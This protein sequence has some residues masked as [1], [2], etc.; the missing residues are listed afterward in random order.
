MKSINIDHQNNTR[1][2]K[3]NNFRELGGYPT[4]D[5]RTLKYR[6]LFRS[7]HLSA[8]SRR[9]LRSMEE[10]KLCSVVDFRS[11]QENEKQPDRLPTGLDYHHF[12][13]LDEGNAQL[14]N[15]IHDRVKNK[16]Y[17]GFDPIIEMSKAYQQFATEFT[18]QY[19]KFLE[20]VLNAEGDAILWHCTAGK[21]RTGFAAAIL[22]RILGVSD[23]IIMQDYLL[24]R[25]YVNPNSLKIMLVG[26]IFGRRAYNMVKPLMEVHQIWLQS[27]FAALDNAWG[28][29]EGY[30]NNGL[31]LMNEDIVQLKHYYLD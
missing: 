21:D 4:R 25:Q 13:I 16:E 2:H 12:S 30:L 31:K 27:A 9:G 10:L 26:L 20:V 24:S 29:F 14:N 5:N 11:V 22:M 19:K 6:K 3:V 8:I 28:D 15:E 7:G 18:P 1:I 17:E 23:E